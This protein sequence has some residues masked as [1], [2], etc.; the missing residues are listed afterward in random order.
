MRN[1]ASDFKFNP[2]TPIT[3]MAKQLKRTPN[4]YYDA[5][6]RLIDDIW[7]DIYN[8][9]KLYGKKKKRVRKDVT[10]WVVE[11][12][13]TK[14]CIISYA[15]RNI[16]L[17]KAVVSERP[18]I[19]VRDRLVFYT[20]DLPVGEI[21]DFVLRGERQGFNIYSSLYRRLKLN[22]NND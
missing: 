20:E 13:K 17:T 3:F 19:Q 7:E 14:R 2:L 22:I 8:T 4:E 18:N 11:F 1:F 15:G 6:Q 5:E 12:T 10:E 9:I 21:S 16:K